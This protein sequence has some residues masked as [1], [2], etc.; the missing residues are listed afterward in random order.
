MMSRKG[1]QGMAL[2]A[3][4]HCCLGL[5]PWPCCGSATSWDRMECTR[6]QH[7]P[8]PSQGSLARV[9]GWHHPGRSHAG[10]PSLEHSPGVR[11][12]P[13]LQPFVFLATVIGIW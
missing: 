8:P 2:P 4:F 1:R 13:P 7:R 9:P 12:G 3:A 10:M 6:A 11:P 5:I